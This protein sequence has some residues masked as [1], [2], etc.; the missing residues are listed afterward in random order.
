LSRYKPPMQVLP[1]LGLCLKHYGVLL[2]WALTAVAMKLDDLRDPFVA[3]RPLGYPNYGHNNGDHAFIA[4]IAA[5]TV[6]LII[7]YL[8]LRPWSY[9]RSWRRSLGALMVAVPWL[10]VSVFMTFHAGGIIAVHATWMLAV[11]ILLLFTTFIS[12]IAAANQRVMNPSVV[13]PVAK[14]LRS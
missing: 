3:D 5:I 4:G 6:E 10:G 2:M 12:A 14:V 8:I 7:L 9:Q 13:L 11:V 1:A